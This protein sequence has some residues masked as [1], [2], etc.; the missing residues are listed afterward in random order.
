MIA[1]TPSSEI[2]CFLIT[3]YLFGDQHGGMGPP[4]L[5]AAV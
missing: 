3:R 4:T 2:I 1:Y 5:P